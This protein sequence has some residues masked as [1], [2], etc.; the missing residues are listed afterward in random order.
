MVAWDVEY[1][2]Q[3]GDWFRGLDADAQDTVVAAVW[4]LQERGPGLGRPFVDT[5][6]TSR[7]P[8]IKELR[9]LGGLLRILFAF[10]PRRIA[11]SLIGGDKSKR[12]QAWYREFIPVADRLY[13]E[14]LATLQE[15]GLLP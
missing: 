8:H 4:A 6:K 7:H 2:D 11:I 10:D 5:V 13:D 15:E 1:T 14:H 9:P 3:F 12:W